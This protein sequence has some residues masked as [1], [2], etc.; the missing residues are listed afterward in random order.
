[1]SKAKKFT[2][3]RCHARPATTGKTC[4]HLNTE[5]NDFKGIEV[6]SACGCTRI[7]SQLRE[8][9]AQERATAGAR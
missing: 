1:M 3:W 2:P 7:A 9:T 5:H 6:C 4:G 8:R